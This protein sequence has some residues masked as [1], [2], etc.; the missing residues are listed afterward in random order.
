L[1]ADCVVAPELLTLGNIYSL[2]ALEPCGNGCPKPVLVMENL[3]IERMSQVGGGR[4][5]RLRLRSGRYSFNAI[6]FSASPET[7]FVNQGDLVDVAFIPQVNEFRGERSVQM[8]VLDIR[9]SCKAEC[10][11]DTTGYHALCDGT[12]TREQ[13]ETLTPDRAVLGTVWRYLMGMGARELRESPMCLCRKIVRW[14]GSPMSLGQL[15][16]CLDIFADVGL[17]EVQ[18]LHKYIILRL[19]PRSDK[20]DLN[21]S[22]TMQRL[23]TA[24]GSDT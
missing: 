20:A 5:M 9:P 21:E 2:N 12:L 16:T 22:R 3:Q 6:Y 19:V 10:A 11:C 18:R 15:L 7:A 8:N 24:K 13:A 4:H 17:L 1:D 23:M 14:S